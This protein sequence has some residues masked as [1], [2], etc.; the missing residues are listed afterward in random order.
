MKELASIR[1]LESQLRDLAN[2]LRA[3]GVPVTV[4]HGGSGVT[5]L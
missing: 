5:K 4:S 2:R 1:E 3:K